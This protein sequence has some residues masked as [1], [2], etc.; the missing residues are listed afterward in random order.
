MTSNKLRKACVKCMVCNQDHDLIEDREECPFDCD[1][2]T[3]H[4]VYGQTIENIGLVKC[5]QTTRHFEDLLL[6][7]EHID[8]AADS[9]LLNKVYVNAK[10]IIAFE[11]RDKK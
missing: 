11:V 7:F 8:A 3:L 9:M 2:V 4:I 6:E 5:D 10:D 1:D